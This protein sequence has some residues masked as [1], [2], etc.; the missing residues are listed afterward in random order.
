MILNNFG[1]I[2]ALKINMNHSELSNLAQKNN[3]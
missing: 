1:T 3:Q 2:L